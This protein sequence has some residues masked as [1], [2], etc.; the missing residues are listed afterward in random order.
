M[1]DV[2]I[3]TNH[4]LV[5]LRLWMD[6]EATL[7]EIAL[8]T[9]LKERAVYA[10]LRDLRNRDFVIRRKVGRRNKYGIRLD[11]V[12]DFQPFD[13][14][15]ARGAVGRAIAEA[16]P[17][18]SAKQGQP[19][20]HGTI[21]TYVNEHPRSTLEDVTRS[22]GISASTALSI[23]RR[24]EGEGI[25]SRRSNGG[26]ECYTISPPPVMARQIETPFT[27]EQIAVALACLANTLRREQQYDPGRGEPGDPAAGRLQVLS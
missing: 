1:R 2:K 8:D 22:L 14:G 17:P 16:P 6:Q 10:I 11:K 5:L 19:S 3:F 23:L 12:L 26:E 20:E 7:S 13:S 15:T 21:L 9:G 27:I 24:L 4:G 25:V 18:S